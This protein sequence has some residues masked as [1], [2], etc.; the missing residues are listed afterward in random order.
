MPGPPRWRTPLLVKHSLSAQKTSLSTINARVAELLKFVQK[1]AHRNPDVV[2]GDGKERS[3]DSPEGRALCR[4]IA[5]EGIVLLKNSDE[6]LPLTP[7]KLKK[8]A[9]IGP[10]AKGT[11]ISGGGSAALKPTYVI[12]PWD[13]LVAGAPEGTELEYSLGCYGQ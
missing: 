12:T 13:G 5:S 9:V 1:Q 4:K 6:L 7:K 2:F 8:I 10:N 11:V 3:R